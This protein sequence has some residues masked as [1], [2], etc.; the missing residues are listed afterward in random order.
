MPTEA[1]DPRFVDID[2]WPTQL[3]VAAMLE[4][5]LAAIAAVAGQ[6]GAIA[7]AAEAAAFVLMR[8]GRLVYVGAGTSGRIA[9][10]DGVELTPTYGWP[11]S[12][13]AFLLAGGIAALA[14]SAEGAEDDAAAGAREINA[15]AIS[16]NDVV[17]GIA[18]SGRTPFT[19]AAIRA[20]KENGALTIGVANNPATPLLTSSAHALLADTGSE[21]IAGSTRMKAGT[22]QKVILNLLSTAIMMRCGLVYKGLMV[23]MH[24]S[25]EK[26][27]KRGQEMVAELGG[28]DPDT[29]TVLLADARNDIKLAIL[30]A[31]GLDRTSAARRLADH[32]QN[33]RL[34][35]CAPA[36]PERIGEG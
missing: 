17:I 12:R 22:A 3:A 9:V 25:N 8:G 27:L 20:A 33:L 11:A 28:V 15:H 13:L 4:G 34:A 5:Q 1:A 29:A 30:M 26:L 23:S 7:D 32:T 31:H 21:P 2:R 10:Q 16:S 14:Q 24:I 36:E 18:A 6:T 35:L 19:V